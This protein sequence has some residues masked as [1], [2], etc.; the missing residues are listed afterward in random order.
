MVDDE[1]DAYEGIYDKLFRTTMKFSVALAQLAPK[2]GNFSDNIEAHLRWVEKARAAGANLVVFPELSLTGY[3]LQDLVPDIAVPLPD[4]TRLHPLLDACRGIDCVFG[5]VE[6][7]SN[8]NY[9]NAAAYVSGG[10]ILH[11]HRKLYLPTYGMFDE[12]RFSPWERI[13][14]RSRHSS[15]NWAS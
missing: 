3:I 12:M 8:F 15:A 4:A 11:V 6:V 1:D 10:K 2:L 13:S 7:S 14:A 5:F 9:Y